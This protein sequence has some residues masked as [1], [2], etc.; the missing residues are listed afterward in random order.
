[1]DVLLYL[2][3]FYLGCKFG[4]I[5]FA[6]RIRHLLSKIDTKDIEI[7]E[8]RTEIKKLITEK[9]GNSILL[10]EVGTNTFICQ[11]STLD[12]L[13]T[14]S[15]SYKNIKIAAVQHDNEFVWFVDGTV[16]NKI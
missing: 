10:Y 12:E 8:T 9:V 11:G 7:I 13:A 16:K 1:M 3:V 15:K 4:E 2:I 6:F 5:I 14:L